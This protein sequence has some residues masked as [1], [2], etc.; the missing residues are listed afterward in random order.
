MRLNSLTTKLTVLTM[1]VSHLYAIDTHVMIVDGRR[2]EATTYMY[3][4]N[5]LS[6]PVKYLGT[7]YNFAMIHDGDK[8]LPPLEIPA[9]YMSPTGNGSAPDIYKKLGM[10][11]QPHSFSYYLR[12]QKTGRINM[13]NAG[14]TDV[15]STMCNGK[16]VKFSTQLWN[17]WQQGAIGGVMKPTTGGAVGGTAALGAITGGILFAQGA[18]VTGG[19]FALLVGAGAGAGGVIG[20]A[21]GAGVAALGFGIASSILTAKSNYGAFR[22]RVA[23]LNVSPEGDSKIT[24]TISDTRLENSVVLDNCLK[25]TVTDIDAPLPGAER[26]NIIPSNYKKDA[27]VLLSVSHLLPK[28]LYQDSCIAATKDGVNIEATCK[29]NAGE[30]AKAISFDSSICKGQDIINVNGTLQCGSGTATAFWNE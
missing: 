10:N 9:G 14:Q 8:S 1:L 17:K 27:A 12:T 19:S 6:D 18:T 24:Q 28:G 29:T 21:V 30:Y 3:L 16:E 13:S 23:Q 15:F 7:S 25:V 26:T 22:A 2:Y 4:A 5:G 20:A 11:F